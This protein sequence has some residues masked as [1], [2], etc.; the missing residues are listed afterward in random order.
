MIEVTGCNGP[1]YLFVN[2]IV[3]VTTNPPPASGSLI[4]VADGAD[5]PFAVKEATAEIL[6]KILDV[7]VMNHG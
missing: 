6:Q 4:Y 5:T 1:V 3:A 7:M 2:H